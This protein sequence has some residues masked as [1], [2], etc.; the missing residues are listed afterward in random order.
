MNPVDHLI[1]KVCKYVSFGQPVSSGSL[2]SQRSSDPRMP[3]QAFY[4]TLQPK[5]EQEHYYHEVWLKKEGSF[6]ITEAWYKDSTVTRSLVQDNISYEQLINAIGEEHSHH[7]VL[8]M[9]EI[10]KKSERED[11]RPYARRA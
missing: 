6:A 10:V 5:S 9:T 8:R 1:K 11:W 4:L 3:M 7:V 2:V